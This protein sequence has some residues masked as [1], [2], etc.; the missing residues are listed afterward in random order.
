MYRH[1]CVVAL[2]LLQGCNDMSDLLSFQLSDTTSFTIQSTSPLSLPFEVATPDVTT[3][4]TQR[5]QNH[6][7]KAELIRDVKLKEVALT[8]TEPADKTFSFLKSIHIYISTDDLEEIELAFLEDIETTSNHIVL[9][10]VEHKLDQYIKSRSYKLRTEVV[11]RE[12][13]TQD[14]EVKADITFSVMADP[15]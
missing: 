7:T 11:T 10:P 13:F 9:A 15:L 8:I 4:S 1:I 5:F 6:N 2:V 14:I 3:N 12:T